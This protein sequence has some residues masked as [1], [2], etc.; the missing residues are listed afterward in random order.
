M[1]DTWN[2]LLNTDLKEQFIQEISRALDEELKKSAV[3]SIIHNF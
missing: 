1:R 3:D 2:D